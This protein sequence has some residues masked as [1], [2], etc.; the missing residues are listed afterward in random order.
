MLIC[1]FTHTSSL[2]IYNFLV[3]LKYFLLQAFHN[4]HAVF[5]QLVLQL[6]ISVNGI[7]N[8]VLYDL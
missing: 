5:V 8:V 2:R 3:N 6:L 4:K 1:I 7:V